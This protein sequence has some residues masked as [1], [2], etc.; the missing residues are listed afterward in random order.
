MDADARE[1]HRRRG[2]R[3]VRQGLG[4]RKNGTVWYSDDGAHFTKVEASGFDSL[5]VGPDG[6]VWAAGFNGTLWRYK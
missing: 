1:R 2:R 5:A 4:G 3:V 6:A